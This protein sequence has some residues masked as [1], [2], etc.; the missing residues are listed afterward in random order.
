MRKAS[1]GSIVGIAV[2]FA[3]GGPALVWAQAV[4]A[5]KIDPMLEQWGERAWNMRQCFGCHELGREQSTG[6]D[7]IGVTDRRSVAWLK[8]WLKDPVEMTADDSIAAALKQQY[9]SQMPNFGLTD[10]DIEGLIQFL[11]Q[12][13]LEKSQAK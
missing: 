6:P 1:L 4:G 2:G 10:R 13:T 11:E 3:L 12:K 5:P 8:K 9:N 7:L